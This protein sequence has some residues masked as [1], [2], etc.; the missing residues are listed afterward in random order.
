VKHCI[1]PATHLY[2]HRNCL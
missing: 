2:L 1:S